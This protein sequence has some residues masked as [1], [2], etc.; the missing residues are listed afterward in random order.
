MDSTI[1]RCP[2]LHN[3]C[4]LLHNHIKPCHTSL[5]PRI[6]QKKGKITIQNS[7]MDA[8]SYIHALLCHTGVVRSNNQEKINVYLKLNYE[9]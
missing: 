2:V 6:R 3:Q 8:V 1:L 7:I 4:S 5:N 9:H